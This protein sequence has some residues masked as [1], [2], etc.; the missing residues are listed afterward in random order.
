MRTTVLTP[1]ESVRSQADE[2]LRRARS[3]TKPAV[4]IICGKAVR[5]Q[6]PDWCVT[7]HSAERLHFEV[8]LHHYGPQMQLSVPMYGGGTEPVLVAHLA[9]WPNATDGDRDRVYLAVAP[10]DSGEVNSLYRDAVN[11]LADQME[12]HAADIR[13]QA[14]LVDT[15]PPR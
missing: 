6:C 10:D 3:A 2:A 15:T 13:R 5:I 1:L 9:Q 14:S 11:A 8:D 12:A 4:A 7:D